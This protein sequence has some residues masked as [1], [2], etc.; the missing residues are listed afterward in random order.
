[1]QDI[2][3]T[4]DSLRAD[5]GLEP[6]SPILSSPSHDHSTYF[7]DPWSPQVDAYT[8]AMLH[9][10]DV[11]PFDTLAPPCEPLTGGSAPQSLARTPEL[12]PT[13]LPRPRPQSDPIHSYR[14]SLADLLS[15]RASRA[16]SPER[17][18]SNDGTAT[19]PSEGMSPEPDQSWTLVP[20]PPKALRQALSHGN[21]KDI[22]S[23]PR[24]GAKS[25]SGAQR[26]LHQQLFSA[27]KSIL[28][29]SPS[30]AQQQTAVSPSHAAATID[31]MAIIDSL[32]IVGLMPARP[33]PRPPR[34]PKASSKGKQK[35]AASGN[36]RDDVKKAAGSERSPV[37]MPREPL[38][39]SSRVEGTALVRRLS[40]D[41]TRRLRFCAT[42]HRV[43]RTDDGSAAALPTS[44]S[45]PSIRRQRGN[46][47]SGA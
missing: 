36:G 15:A 39:S 26:S 47:V 23:S 30:V 22:R 16:Q 2:K 1:M 45:S 43:R 27:A 19:T 37:L 40:T 7:A 29:R 32:T 17:R 28:Q 46:I 33:A 41:A 21:L 24:M 35:V 10:D 12:R 3:S 5:L 13:S 14:D 18:L 8:G 9:P 6:Q 20:D 25:S 44:T 4:I 11:S 34:T 38:P 31:S 42:G